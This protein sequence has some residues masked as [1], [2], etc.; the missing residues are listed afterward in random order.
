MKNFCL[1]HRNRKPINYSQFED[2]GNDSDG[3]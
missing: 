3:K 1:I 2:S